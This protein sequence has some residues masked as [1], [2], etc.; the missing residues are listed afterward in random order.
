[1]PKELP[2]YAQI[3]DMAIRRSPD[4]IMYVPVDHVD[5]DALEALAESKGANS[6][7]MT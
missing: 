3:A 4:V 6:I 2:N 5:Y 7:Y 1:V